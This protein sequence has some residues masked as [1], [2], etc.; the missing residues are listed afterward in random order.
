MPYILARVIFQVA[1]Q[2]ALW[3]R[4]GTKAKPV[5]LQPKA[6]VS[7][8]PLRMTE[9]EEDSTRFTSQGLTPLTRLEQQRQNDMEERITSNRKGGTSHE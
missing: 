2:K 7:S 3:N 1:E 4:L 8:T 5:A 6:G 9:G